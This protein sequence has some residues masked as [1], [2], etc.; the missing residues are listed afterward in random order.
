MK[1]KI[2]LAGELLDKS[3]HSGIIDV[4]VEFVADTSLLFV[5][6]RHQA[7]KRC[8]ELIFFAGLGRKLGNTDDFSFCFFRHCFSPLI[9]QLW[10]PRRALFSP[11]AFSGP[12][13]KAPGLVPATK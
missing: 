10:S 8:N 9:K 6:R 7:M 13:D 12:P 2:F 1:V 5:R 11:C 3:D 4:L